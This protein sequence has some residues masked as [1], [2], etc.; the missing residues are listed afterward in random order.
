M[1]SAVTSSVS[2]TDLAGRGSAEERPVSQFSDLEI[3]HQTQ[4]CLLQRGN[5][6]FTLK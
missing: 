2:D 6:P 5:G 4:G 3:Y 1:A